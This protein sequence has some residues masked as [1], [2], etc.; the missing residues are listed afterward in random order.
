MPIHIRPVTAELIGQ[1][2]DRYDAADAPKVSDLALA[3]A[4]LDRQLE[5]IE[6]IFAEAIDLFA[7]KQLD[8]DTS[9][10]ALSSYLASHLPRCA[11]GE[12]SPRH[13]PISAPTVDPDLKSMQRNISA[14]ASRIESLERKTSAAASNSDGLERRLQPLFALTDSINR[15]R[16]AI[17]LLRPFAKVLRAMKRKT[18]RS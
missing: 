16:A 15:N 11:E 4:S 9:H 5:Q 18:P 3:A 13:R 8:D 6:A 14:V 12:A 17:D 10:R 2:I 1:E 7:K